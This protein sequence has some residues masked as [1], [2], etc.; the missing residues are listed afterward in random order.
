[1]TA[2]ALTHEFAA[3]KER[4]QKTLAISLVL[5]LLLFAWLILR[6]SISEAPEGIVEIAWLDPVPQA[7]P[8][9]QVREPAKPAP[10]VKAKVVPPSPTEEKFQREQQP[11]V[12][13]PT[14]QELTANRDMVKERL[15]ALTPAKLPSTAL[16]A[17]PRTTHSL[18]SS[19]PV[20]APDP[21]LKASAVDLNR[22]DTVR[23]SPADL[24]RGPVEPKRHAPAIV[25]ATVETPLA[26]AAVPD[27]ESVARRTLEGAELAGQIANRPVIS[28]TMPVYPE[29]AKS[30]AVEAT[31]TL[32]FVVLP[33]GRVKENIQVQKTAGFADFDLSAMAALEKWRFEA[34]KNGAPN[35]Q[36]GTITFRFRLRN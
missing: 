3:S 27:M 20:E 15:A 29:W 33:D 26:A 21:G 24:K 5:H 25:A 13:A 32:Y 36:W 11:A 28:H 8:P 34:L 18:L 17:E 1:M 23:P 35:E 2:I 10:V 30:Q 16:T 9:V 31:V 4:F 22:A 14:P 19:A 6:E 12:V 7:P